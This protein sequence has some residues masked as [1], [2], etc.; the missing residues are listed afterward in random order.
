MKTA[1]VST[2]IQLDIKND[3]YLS[4]ADNL[5]NSYLKFTNFDIVLLTNNLEYFSNI[6]DSRLK[7]FDYNLN[8]KE[9]IMSAKRFNMH[10]KRRPIEIASRLG[11]DIIF[12]NDCD[13]FITGW[14][15]A[16]FKKK[17]SEDFDVAFVSHANPQLGGLR[18]TYKH[19]QEKIDIEF[20][21]LYYDELDL[22]PNPAETRVIFK[23][24]EKLKKFLHF[25]N[26]ISERNKDY[27]TYHDG[28][29]F[30][31]SAIYAKMN[32][33]GVTHKD[34][35]SNF[36]RISHGEEILN[37]FGQKATV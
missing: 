31:T 24:N 27:F 20:G 37:Y 30:G 6:T 36:C 5:I 28:V 4:R 8:F 21:D 34:E 12:Y 17:C 26:L 3:Q 13:C 35:F 16:S 14:D 18:K 23:N 15:E 33:I 25:W 7:L 1:V 19:F 10:I 2:S 32:M 9:P 29:Y 11:Y 22:S